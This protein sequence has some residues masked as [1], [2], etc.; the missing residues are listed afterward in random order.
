MKNDIRA[1]AQLKKSGLLMCFAM[2]AFMAAVII[3]GLLVIAAKET[4]SFRK[5]YHIT[6]GAFFGL[7]IGINVFWKI[8]ISVD[9]I[10]RGLAF[11]MPR[12]K[13]F[14]YSRIVDFLEIMIMTILACVLLIDVEKSIIITAAGCCYVLFMLLEGLVANNIIK[15]GKIAYWI[16][17]GCF[18]FLCFVGPHL[19]VLKKGYKAIMSFIFE[20]V[21]NGDSIQI[22]FWIGIVVA[23]IAG[24]L[25]NWLTFRKIEVKFNS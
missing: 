20:T 16:Y 11:G 1:I 12:K 14:I 21:P 5:A 2:F 15:Y 22:T 3:I 13:L 17:Y 25:I 23:V 24:I 18:M 7:Y 6:V 19:A 9:E 4:E 8:L 10:P